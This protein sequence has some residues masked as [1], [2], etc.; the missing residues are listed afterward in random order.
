MEIHKSRVVALNIHLNNPSYYISRLSTSH[1]KWLWQ[2][3]EEI[4]QVFLLHTPTLIS[5]RILKPLLLES[6]E[7]LIEILE[8]VF[9][10]QVVIIELLY[11]DENKEI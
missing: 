8:D 3:S 4:V 1:P 2:F 5:G 7:L 10:R 9:L 6:L 11:D